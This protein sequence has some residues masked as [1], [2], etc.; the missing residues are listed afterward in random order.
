MDSRER[1]F[2]NQSARLEPAPREGDLIFLDGGFVYV[3]DQSESPAL[4]LGDGCFEVIATTGEAF[5]VARSPERDLELRSAV[6][7]DGE[8]RAWR[9][10]VSLRSWTAA[11]SAALDRAIQEG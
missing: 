11:E 5:L 7:D 1:F 2:M 10:T 4:P 3:G 8:R 6:H 9:A